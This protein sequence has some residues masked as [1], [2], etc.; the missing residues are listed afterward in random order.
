M[1]LKEED[2][3]VNL[4]GIHPDIIFNPHGMPSRMT[5]A[6]LIESLICNVCA[7]KGTHFDGTI[8]KKNDIESYAEILEQYG[9]NRYGYDRMISGVTG[10]FIDTLIFFGPTYYQRLQKFVSD[11][12]YAV[13]HALT[14][15]LTNQPLDQSRSKYYLT[16][17]MLVYIW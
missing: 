14:D 1:L 8:F 10:E 13:S 7:I 15:A 12:E 11:A 9:M 2:M 6:Q 5:C 3:P 4:E 16:T 17:V